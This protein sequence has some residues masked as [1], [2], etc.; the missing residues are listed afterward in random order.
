MCVPVRGQHQERMT[1]GVA[2]DDRAFTFGQRSSTAG[3]QE[4]LRISPEG[5]VA[6]GAAERQS[7]SS[8]ERPPPPT[9]SDPCDDDQRC[10]IRYPSCDHALPSPLSSQPP[11]EP[12]CEQ[13]RRLSST[14]HD[15][16]VNPQVKKAEQ[17]AFRGGAP[18]LRCGGALF[19]RTRAR[20]HLFCA[21]RQSTTGCRGRASAGG[22]RRGWHWGEKK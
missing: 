7:P 14:G 10:R 8:P 9:G 1:A 13:T 11:D 3:H 19:G 2:D 4:I 5:N 18:L 21:H 15:L 16:R 12:N 20:Q 22:P 17:L 6:A